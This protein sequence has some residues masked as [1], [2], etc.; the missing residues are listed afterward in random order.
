MALSREVVT[1]QIAQ[2]TAK[3]DARIKVLAERK[4]DEKATKKDAVLKALMSDLKDV[5]KRMQAIDR[6]AKQNA[7]LKAK[8]EG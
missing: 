5:N 1:N 2:A 6:M 4:L 3:R 7:E 8:K